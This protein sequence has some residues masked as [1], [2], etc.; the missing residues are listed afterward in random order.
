MAVLKKIGV[1]SMAKLYGVIFA[2]MGLIAGIFMGLFGALLAAFGSAAGGLGLA[3]I[4][5]LP[6]IY[7]IMGFVSG[8][9]GAFLYNLF[10]GWVGGIEVDLE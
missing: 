9:I 2:V 8:A 10:A 3:A 1:M 4:I 6:I 7:G 5:V